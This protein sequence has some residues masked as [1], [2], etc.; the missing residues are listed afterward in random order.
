MLTQV[1]EVATPSE[2]EAISAIGVDHVGVLVGDGAFPRELPVH[3]AAAVMK[4]IQP[5]SVLSALFLSSDVALI[6]RMVRE[7]NPPIVHLGASIELITPDHVVALRKSLP[8]IKFMRSVPV[9]GPLAVDVARAYDGIVDWILLDSHRIGDTQ[10]GA[11]GVTHDWSISRTIVETVRTPV[12]L[13]GGLGPDNVKEAIRLV[14]PAGV[15]SKTKT[16][17]ESVHSKDLAKVK[18]FH[19]AAKSG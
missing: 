5:P 4:A 19:R 1:Y 9:T 14:Q 10:I 7:L 12:I 6:E 8:K 15:D 13:A 2:A 16:D 18:A 17:R 3:K 11:Q